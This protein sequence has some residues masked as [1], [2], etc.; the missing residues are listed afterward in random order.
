[1]ENNHKLLE[2]NFAFKQGIGTNTNIG[3]TPQFD[4]A[5]AQI[6]EYTDRN[7]YMHRT[8]VDA[9]ITIFAIKRFRKSLFDLAAK[10]IVKVI[11]DLVLNTKYDNIWI[12]VDNLEI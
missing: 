10:E 9:C 12:P 1:M 5:M 2:F 8:S 11:V 6:K 4:A 3:L 7:N